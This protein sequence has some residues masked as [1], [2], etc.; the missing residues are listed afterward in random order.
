MLKYNGLFFVVKIQN[1]ILSILVENKTGV[2]NRVTS[3]FRRRR[4]N[5]ESLTVSPSEKKGLSRMTIEVHHQANIEQ[6]I[7]QIYKIIEVIKVRQLDPE[8]V[9]VRDLALVTFKASSRG[10][11][12]LT[13][14]LKKY[15][16][17][18]T[19]KKLTT[20]WTVQI[21]DTPET[22]DTFLKEA[23]KHGLLHISRTGATATDAHL[24]RS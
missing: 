14:F 1:H 18:K 5:I 17:T 7:K 8:T 21:V 19:I 22:I 23:G 13:A 15:R 12:R 9:I 10:N 11:A 6:A 24:P 4:F 16:T 3:L 20:S 2:L